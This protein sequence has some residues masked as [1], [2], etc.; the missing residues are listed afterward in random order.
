MRI[1]NK[2]RHTLEINDDE[3]KQCQECHDNQKKTKP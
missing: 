2:S 1:V 3:N